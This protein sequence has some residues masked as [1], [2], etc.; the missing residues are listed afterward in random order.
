M[1][2][3]P[4][5]IWVRQLTLDPCLSSLFTGNV[6][7]EVPSFHGGFTIPT[8]DNISPHHPKFAEAAGRDP[9]HE[10]AI[11]CGKGL[12]MLAIRALSDPRLVETAKEQFQITKGD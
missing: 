1:H 9:A 3:P 6:S 11:K 2:L 12:A 4:Q 10:A 8:E 7:H 5:P